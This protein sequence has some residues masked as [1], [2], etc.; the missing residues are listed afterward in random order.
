MLQLFLLITVIVK[1]FSTNGQTD[2]LIVIMFTLSISV[3]SFLMINNL[4]KMINIDKEQITIKKIVNRTMHVQKAQI[5]GYQNYKTIGALGPEES[6]YIYLNDGRKIGIH[7]KAYSNFVAIKNAVR[8]LRLDKI[9]DYNYEKTYLKPLRTALP[10]AFLIALVFF[11]I[12]KKQFGNYL[13]KK[14][15]M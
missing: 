9:E 7:E 10:I 4:Y 5:K 8:A 3:F 11:L 14:P 15:F 6:V 13:Y 12:S 1:V 2:Y